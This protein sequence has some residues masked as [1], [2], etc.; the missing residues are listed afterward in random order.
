MST[1]SLDEISVGIKSKKKEAEN[2]AWDDSST[3]IS[4]KRNNS[5][6]RLGPTKDYDR[7]F[8]FH[9][10]DRLTPVDVSLKSNGMIIKSPLFLLNKYKACPSFSLFDALFNF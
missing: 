2:E 3:Y 10:V 8:F 5:V 4:R 1:V 9:R 6:E 7:F